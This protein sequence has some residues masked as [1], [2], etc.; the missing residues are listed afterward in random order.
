MQTNLFA[1]IENREN[2]IKRHEGNPRERAAL[3][4]S[5]DGQKIMTKA[6]RRTMKKIKGASKLTKGEKD[7]YQKFDNV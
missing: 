4:A 5:K 2:S 1:A 3:I 7:F 6:D